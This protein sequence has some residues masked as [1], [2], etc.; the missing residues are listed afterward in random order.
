[1]SHILSL[2]SVKH[3]NIPMNSLIQR[4]YLSLLVK[5]YNFA[6]CFDSLSHLQAL[7][8]QSFNV[9]WIWRSHG[10]DCESTVFRFITLCISIST[11]HIG[12]TYRLHLQGWRVSQ[13]GNEQKEAEV[14][15]WRLIF[16]RQ[17][18]FSEEY[19]TPI[20]RVNYKSS[21]KPVEAGG[22]LSLQPGSVP[23]KRRAVSEIG[24]VITQKTV[25]P[26]LISVYVCFL[27]IILNI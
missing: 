4:T 11:L 10:G 1:M 26:M 18:H 7:H 12:G 24:G 17:T 21:K 23:P 14:W 3:N 8:W 9:C 19:I 2:I 6:T 5:L 20:I 16:R 15:A 13:A 25:L 22:I 27:I